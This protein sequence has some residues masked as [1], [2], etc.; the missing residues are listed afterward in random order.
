MKG[1]KSIA[2]ALMKK[3]GLLYPEFPSTFYIRR[4]ETLR[5]AASLMGKKGG[6]A[7]SERKTKAVRKNGAMPPRPGSR[8]RGR[9]NKGK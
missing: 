7:K 5:R 4:A 2:T 8:P 3:D 9:P 1:T 6:S